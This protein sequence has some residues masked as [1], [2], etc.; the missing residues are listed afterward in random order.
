MDYDYT[1]IR[2][3]KSGSSGTTYFP[4]NGYEKAGT[5]I[6]KYIKIGIETVAAK[7]GTQKLF[8]HND[9]LGGVN[10]ISDINGLRV[11]LA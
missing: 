6:T 8:Y 7:K 11:Q 10:V 4:F 1:G 3:K 5:L 2:V 9:H